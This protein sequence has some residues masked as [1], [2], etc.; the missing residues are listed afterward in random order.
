MK[1]VVRQF[2][3]LIQKLDFLNGGLVGFLSLHFVDG[4]FF[5]VTVMSDVIGLII[6]LKNKKKTEKDNKKRNYEADT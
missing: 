1:S 5:L 2:N 3:R 4:F 6:T